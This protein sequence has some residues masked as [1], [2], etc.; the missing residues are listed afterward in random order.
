MATSEHLSSIETIL[1]GARAEYEK[2]KAELLQLLHSAES[3]AILHEGLATEARQAQAFAERTAT[4]LLTQF[5]LVEH[6]FSDVKKQALEFGFSAKAEVDKIRSDIATAAAS[7]D[8]ATFTIPEGHEAVRDANGR[9]TGE[10]RP[11]TMPDEALA[12]SLATKAI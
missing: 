7:E 11:I 10:T 9:A 6:I 5:A 1:A 4:K 3:K 2:E 8:R 12:S